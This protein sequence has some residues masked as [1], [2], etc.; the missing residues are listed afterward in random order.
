MH[1][2][3]KNLLPKFTAILLS[4]IA[5]SSCEEDLS[6]INS[7]IIGEQNF[8][9]DLYVTDNL[10][11]FS[12]K[13]FPVQT[14]NLPSYQLGI[15]NNEIYGRSTVNLLSQ[16]TMELPNPEF[17]DSTELEKVYL[18]IPFFSTSTVSD[19]VTT[20]ELDS[21]Y[22]DAPINITLYESNY[23]LRDFDPNS[24][25]EEP[26]KY[27]SNQGPL[28]ENFLGPVIGT[29]EEFTPSA[30]EIIA[31]EDD[32]ATEEDEEERLPPGLRV[33]LPIEFFKEKILDKEGEPELLN[34]NNFKNYFRGIYFK[35]T[36]SSNEGNLFLFNAAAARI[37]LEYT[38]KTMGAD[39]DA[40]RNDASFELSL[41]GINVNTFDNELN[42]DIA[43]QLLT[44]D[45][46]NGEENLYLRGGDGIISVIDLF[47]DVDNKKILN[48]VLVDGQNG[49][50]DELDSLRVENWLIN[51]ANLIFYVDQSKIPGGATEPERLVIFN[52][53]EGTLLADYDFDPT[54]GEAPVN[55]VVDHL[56]RLERGSDENGDFYKIRITTH[57]S[58]VIRRDSLNVPLGIMVTQN[59]L[60]TDFQDLE[61]TQSPGIDKVPAAT[62]LSPQGTVLFG[63]NTANSEKRL[64]LQIYYTKP[65]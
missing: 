32:P 46:E 20:Y 29:V 59:V 22:G 9:S 34:N 50:P 52:I 42:P 23:F 21:V 51:E 43:S 35:V 27:Y 48:G 25:F 49:V 58:N 5:L 7:E 55:A 63:N 61:N 36:S 4:I 47:G 39:P 13:L 8:N 40:E 1:M 44:P 26:Q 60:V 18:Y 10:V 37:T 53:T 38:F 2:N 56:G 12:R 54:V 14:N 65:N 33:E 11:A 41:K 31:V 15:Y 6:P 28:F 16:V 19:E 45:V 57:L 64:K 30:D 62:I 3:I 24:N 17:G